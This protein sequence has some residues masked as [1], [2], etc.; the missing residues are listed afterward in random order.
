MLASGA[1]LTRR[2]ATLALVPVDAEQRDHEEPEV[3]VEFGRSRWAG[4]GSG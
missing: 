1:R 3:R 4:R 2:K